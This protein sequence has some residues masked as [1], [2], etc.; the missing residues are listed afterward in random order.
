MPKVYKVYCQDC[1]ELLTN[2]AQ[3]II[4]ISSPG[5]HGFSTNIPPSNIK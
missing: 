4:L 5:E 3:A 1:G 2:R